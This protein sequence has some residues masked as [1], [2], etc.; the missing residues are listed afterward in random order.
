M[1]SAS[2]PSD[3]LAA[4]VRDDLR[5]KLVLL[6]SLYVSQAIP[7]GFFTVAL[8]AILR[9]Q[10]RPLEQIGLVSALALPWLLKFLWAPLVDRFGASRFGHFRSWILPLQTL[11][12]LSVVVL[13]LLDPTRQLGLLVA[14]GALFM[15]LAAT[16]D[17]ATDGLAVHSLRFV[18]RGPA[19]GLQVGG[20][21]LGLILGGGVVLVLFER[22]GWRLALL[23]MAACLALPLLPLVRFREAA[24]ASAPIGSR[25][26]F[27]AL[28]SFLR[29]PGGGRWLAV[30]LVYRAAETAALTMFNPLLVDLGRSLEEIGVL[31]GMV[32]AAASL[33]GA[34]LGGL[35]VIRL[36]RR[37]A[38]SWFALA[39]AGAVA[40]LVLP[41][42]GS[43]AAMLCAAAVAVAFAGGL[44][45]ATLYTNMMDACSSESA[46]TDFTL[47]QS[48]A[49]VGPLVASSV[50]GLVAAR[51]GYQ[52]LF[53]LASLLAAAVAWLVAGTRMPS[54]QRAALARGPQA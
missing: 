22:L 47:Q 35:A 43:G 10:G 14:T 8:P 45:T 6:A 21:Y 17:I 24:R 25:P 42:R 41:A 12:A 53:V 2:I 23:A 48:M 1:T 37:R 36:G 3:R 30:V 13:A 26:G 52:G 15:L 44:A 39:L 40:L 18:E 29:R 32:N 51:L 33:A 50:S 34:M 4:P 7:L 46:A 49:A 38:L 9:R 28:A 54:E 27:G 16:Q 20:Y 31:L 5:I 11:S 19:N